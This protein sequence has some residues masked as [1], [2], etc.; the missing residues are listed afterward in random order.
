MFRRSD[1][2]PDLGFPTHEYAL[3]RIG[4]IQ[5]QSE[6]WWDEYVLARKQAEE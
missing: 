6:T 3:R 1:Q 5:R 2:L 4:E